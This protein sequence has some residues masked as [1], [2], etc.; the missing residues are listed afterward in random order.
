LIAY[1]LKVDTSM[2][3][4]EFSDVIETIDEL[5]AIVGQPSQMVIDKVQ[6]GIDELSAA[7]IAASPF[8][9]IATSDAEGNLDVSPKGDPA[10]FVQVL[11]ETTLLIPDRPGNRRVD[12]LGNIL[13]NPKVGLI[14]LIPGKEETLRVNGRAKLVRDTH[15]RE[16]C[17]VKGKAP[18]LLIA[19][20]ADEV[21]FHCAKCMIRSQLWDSLEC[22]T[23]VPTLAEII[24]RQA[25]VDATVEEVQADLDAGYAATLY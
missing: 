18:T 17:V 20:S 16:Q 21:F 15:L 5:R 11:N 13:Q 6:P 22:L 3:E 24:V 19:V 4:I 12:T 8:V 1:L 14:F 7:W 25:K 2:A 10:G 9:L 23:P